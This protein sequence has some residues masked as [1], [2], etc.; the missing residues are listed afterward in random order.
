KAADYTTIFK[1]LKKI[2]IEFPLQEIDNDII[3]AMDSTGMN[4]SSR[5]EW[6]RHKW[7]LENLMKVGE[8]DL[9]QYS[10]QIL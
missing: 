9:F 4:V 7:N 6:I 3:L 8:E 1:R 5:G 10:I 2:K